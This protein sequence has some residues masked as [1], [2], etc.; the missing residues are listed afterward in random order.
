MNTILTCQKKYKEM[1]S[2]T[3]VKK[4]LKLL[5]KYIYPGYFEPIPQDCK[6]YLSHLKDEAYT[7][8]HKEILKVCTDSNLTTLF[9]D[10]L[11]EIQK[12]I[13]WDVLAT[14]QGDPAASNIHEIVLTYPG[15]YAITIYRIAHE[16]YLLKI[17]LI[18]RMLSELAHSK[19]GID[20]HPGAQIGNYFFIDHGTGIVI[21]ETA[22]IGN[23]VR[24]Y[25]GVTLGALSLRKGQSLKGE[26]RHPTI[27][28]NVT[29]Y[30]GASILGG[31]TVI[32]KNVTIGSNVFITESVK[33]DTLVVLKKP[34]LILKEKKQ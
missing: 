23:N 27:Q 25:Q 18:P 4:A 32:E 17:P 16:L 26:K 6:T 1:P 7:L 20:I 10:Q 13:E 31:K 11:D 5:F 24:I 21:G 34:D 15:I 12:K 8:L 14:F 9:F 28:D 29:I 2:L 3:N 19:T 30:A 22:V 33:E